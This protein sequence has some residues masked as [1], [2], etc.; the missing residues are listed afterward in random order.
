MTHATAHR[1]PDSSPS[2]P[3][4]DPVA[5]LIV[6]AFDAGQ[7]MP[8]HERL[9]DVDK[10]LREEIGRLIPLARDHT[11]RAEERSRTWYALTSAADSAEYACRFELGSGRLAGA[12]HVA[13]LARRVIKLRRVLGVDS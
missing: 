5:D 2:E 13:E 12:L 6:E 4:V 11:A 8:P 10:L 7:S 1:P 9:V 3:A